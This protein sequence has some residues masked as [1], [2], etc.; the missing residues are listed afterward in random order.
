MIGKILLLEPSTDIGKYFITLEI[1]D[2]TG[3]E[4]L[5]NNNTIVDIKIK[6][7]S[8]KRSLNANNYFHLL[9]GKIAE[10]EEISATACKNRLVGFYGQPLFLKNDA[11]AIVKSNL[12]PEIVQEFEEPHMKYIKTGAD[13]AFFY[14]IY[15]G[16]HTYNKEEMARLIEGTV[17]EAEHLGIETITPEEK[18]RLLELWKPNET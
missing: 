1:G 10:K 4:E 2:I 9:C 8:A 16:T 13:G 18:Q 11:P 17:I 12:I 6:K 3:L 7:H 15:R 14:K 5:K